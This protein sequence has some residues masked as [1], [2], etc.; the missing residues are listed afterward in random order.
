MFLQAMLYF[1]PN[2]KVILCPFHEYILWLF[3]L[4]D[5]YGSQNITLVVVGIV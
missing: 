2:Q 1:E 5:A 3:L 4:K